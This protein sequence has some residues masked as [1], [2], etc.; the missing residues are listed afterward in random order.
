MAKEY[1]IIRQEKP[2]FPLRELLVVPHQD[3][4]LI[5]SYPFFGPSTLN[6]NLVEMGKTYSHPKTGEAITFREPTTSESISASAFNFAEIAKPVFFN[7]N[8]LQA[9]RIARWDDG[10]YIN[11]LG[12][13]REGNLDETL[14]RKLRDD[15]KTFGKGKKA[16]RLGVNDFAFVPY[17]SFERGVQSAGDFAEGGLARGLEYV[18]GDVA[19]KLKSMALIYPNGVCVVNFNESKE[20]TASIVGLYTL[21]YESGEWL[22]VNGYDAR[23]WKSSHEGCASGV[24][25][26][27]TA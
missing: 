7:P 14:L 8:W 18:R 23:D 3:E 16:I 25:A 12:A 17:E 21:N 27:K 15:S 4:D 24:L 1:G 5:V 9:G 26:S 11:T 2:Q 19:P 20:L 22:Y 6:G 13:M 10:V